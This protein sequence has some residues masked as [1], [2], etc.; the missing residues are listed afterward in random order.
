ML[1]RAAGTTEAG[2][3]FRF[4]GGPGGKAG[5][6]GGGGGG[7]VCGGGRTIST[8]SVAAA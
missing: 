2:R 4:G 6:G 8:R 7:R 3:L 5:A 1:S